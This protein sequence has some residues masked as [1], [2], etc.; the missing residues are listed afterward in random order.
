MHPEMQPAFEFPV[1]KKTTSGSYQ[2][3]FLTHIDWAL[4]DQLDHTAAME[5]HALIFNRIVERTGIL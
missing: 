3:D 1:H 5:A 2:G 4:L